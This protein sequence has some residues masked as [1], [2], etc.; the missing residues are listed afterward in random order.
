[1]EQV[2]KVADAYDLIIFDGAPHS[3]QATRALALASDL[4]VIPTGLAV[5]DL[6]PSVTLAHELVKAGVPRSHL[7]FALCRVG[8]SPSEI[9]DA[10]QYLEQAGY[11]VLAG[12][13]PEQVAYRRASDE[14]RALTETRFSTLNQRAEELAQALVDK[15]GERSPTGRKPKPAPTRTKRS[16]A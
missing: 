14:G 13:L 4:T 1:L 2:L 3:S 16:V 15:I 12:S 9:E 8:N 10:R 6:Q 5:D 11:P 7:V